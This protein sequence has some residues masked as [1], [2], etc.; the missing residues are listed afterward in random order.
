MPCALSERYAQSLT[1]RT[2]E[3]KYLACST[4]LSKKML[5]CGLGT[6]GEQSGETFHYL[7]GSFPKKRG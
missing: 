3:L 6:S 7:Y 2:A 5:A 4:R 1:A